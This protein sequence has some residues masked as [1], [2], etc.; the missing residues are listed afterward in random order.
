MNCVI[1]VLVFVS[2][3]GFDSNVLPS[4]G[5]V[6]EFCDG[7]LSWYRVVVVDKTDPSR[8]AALGHDPEMYNLAKFDE[9]LL[10]IRLPQGGWQVTE[11]KVGSWWPVLEFVVVVEIIDWVFVLN[12]V[13]FLNSVVNIYFWARWRL[14]KAALLCLVIVVV[15]LVFILQFVIEPV[16]DVVEGIWLYFL[17]LFYHEK[18]VSFLLEPHVYWNFCTVQIGLFVKV[19]SRQD[20]WFL[21]F[22]PHQGPELHLI[23]I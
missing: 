2:A 11:V 4:Q 9:D 6:V 16:K 23:E 21:F 18:I 14:M 5:G 3:V 17:M 10:Q 15:A 8:L 7:L 19:F 20:C 1:F 12:Y 13:E 22:I